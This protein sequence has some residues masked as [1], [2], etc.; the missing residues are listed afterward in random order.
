MV[1]CWTCRTM[2]PTTHGTTERQS[3]KMAIQR[4]NCRA[5]RLSELPDSYRKLFEEKRV[6]AKAKEAMKEGIKAI[7]EVSNPSPLASWPK[8]VKAFNAF[9][10]TEDLSPLEA[11]DIPPEEL[12]AAWAK[13]VKEQE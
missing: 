7:K 5:V 4:W 1:I 12:A 2:G 10:E 6:R 11:G 9:L 3:K 8:E 13:W